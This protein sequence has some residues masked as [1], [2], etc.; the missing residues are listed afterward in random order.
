MLARPFRLI[1]PALAALG[2]VALRL[3][4]PFI[5][6]VSPPQPGASDDTGVVFRHYL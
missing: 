3:A 2:L 1:A 4:S 5:G 6:P